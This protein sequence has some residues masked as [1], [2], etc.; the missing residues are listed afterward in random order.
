VS[1]GEHPLL[2]A[3]VI[4][5]AQ[6]TGL[7]ET[8]DESHFPD[9]CDVRT[10]NP[11]QHMR[12]FAGQPDPIDPSRFTIDYETSDGRRTIQGTLGSDDHVEMKITRSQGFLPGN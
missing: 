7:P 9:S 5:P 2:F 4:V 8:L 11:G 6:W 3:K 10:A 1:S 12:I